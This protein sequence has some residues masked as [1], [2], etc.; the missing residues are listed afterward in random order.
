[1]RLDLEKIQI[2]NFY[3]YKNVIYDNFKRGNND[4]APENY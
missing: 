4:Y 2:E 1:M 3:S